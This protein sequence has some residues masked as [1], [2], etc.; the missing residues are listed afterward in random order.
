MILLDILFYRLFFL[1]NKTNKSIPEWSTIILI[2]ILQF[3][4]L[5]SVLLY[6]DIPIEKIGKDMFRIIP[7]ILIGINW[8]YFLMT[9]RYE[10]ILTIPPITRNIKLTDTIIILYV[11]FSIFFF[12]TMLKIKIKYLMLTYTLLSIV[13]FIAYFDG[14]RRKKRE[15]R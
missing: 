3:F 13:S 4:N 12:F 7:V 6:F 9:K 10:K 1:A 14:K 2:S 5:I 11:V 8:I 15:D